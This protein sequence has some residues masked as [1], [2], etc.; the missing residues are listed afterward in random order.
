MNNHHDQIDPEV[1]RPLEELIK[2]L[3]GAINAIED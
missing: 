2:S 1:R 3:P